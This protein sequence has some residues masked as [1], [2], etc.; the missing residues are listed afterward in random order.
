MLQGH[1][2]IGGS[3]AIPAKEDRFL[4]CWVL[5]AI[6]FRISSHL[7]IIN[8]LCIFLGSDKQNCCLKGIENSFPSGL[9][10]ASAS[11]LGITSTF[12]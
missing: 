12:D 1:K 8:F 11:C 2:L 7:V 10:F 6:A 4:S 5:N 9:R 3:G